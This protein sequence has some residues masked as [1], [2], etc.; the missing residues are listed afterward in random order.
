[1]GSTSSHFRQTIFVRLVRSVIAINR[2]LHRGH[3]L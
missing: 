1:M 2:R 3:R